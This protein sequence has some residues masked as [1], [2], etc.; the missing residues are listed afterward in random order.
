MCGLPSSSRA[1]RTAHGSQC[2][3]LR[4]MTSQAC[5]QLS[6]CPLYQSGGMVPKEYLLEFDHSSMYNAIYEEQA[7]WVSALKAAR[8]AGQRAAA[9]QRSRGRSQRNRLAATAGKKI[10]Y[11]FSELVGQMGYEL[12]QRAPTPKRPHLTSVLFSVGS[13]KRLRKPD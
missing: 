1:W 3:P 13:N 6:P 7:Y 9:T 2:V 4:L 12:R 5:Q 10:H 11:D 8:C